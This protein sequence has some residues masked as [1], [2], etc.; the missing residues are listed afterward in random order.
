MKRIKQKKL[1]NIINEFNDKKTYI[2]YLFGYANF[3]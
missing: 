3:V 2:R 1:E